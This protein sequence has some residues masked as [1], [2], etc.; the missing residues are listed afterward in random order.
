MEL[1]RK[2][3][4]L[5]PLETKNK[6]KVWI[7]FLVIIATSLDNLNVSGTLTA[8]FSIT[9]HFPNAGTTTISWVFSAYSLTLGA[10]IIIAGKL[11][12]VLGP[13]NV[14]LCGLFF[15]SIF[16]LI[17]A[18][19]V[20]EPI[21]LIVFRAIQGIFASS[22][23]PSTFAM[24]GNY[25]KGDALLK[26]LTGFIMSLTTV[27]GIGCILG[28]AFSVSSAGYKGL[29]YFTFAVGMFSFI[30]LFFLIIPIDETE[31][32]KNLKIKDL[33]FGGSFALVAGLLLIILGLTEGGH[34]WQK[35]AAYVP[36]IIG[37]LVL[38][39][40]ILFEMVYIQLFK[41]KVDSQI[42]SIESNTTHLSE[43]NKDKDELNPSNQS[44]ET[45]S[46]IPGINDWRYKIQL[47]FPREVV[48]I[49]NFYQY[50]ASTFLFYIN[51]IAVMTT[52]IQYY[53][54]VTLDSPIMT[55]VK[56]LPLALGLAVGATV[57][58]QRYAEKFGLKFVI[59]CSPIIVLTMCVWLS[60]LDFR[61]KNSYWKYE[62]FAQFFIGY[63][64]NL[65]FQVY[66]TD[67]IIGTP[68]HLQGVVS[69]ILQTA[70]QI[71]ICF[72]NA[73]IASLVGDLTLDKS[74]ES[75][76]KLHDKFKKNFYLAFA[77]SGALFL[78]LLTTKKT[79]KMDQTPKISDEE[80]GVT[81]NEVEKESESN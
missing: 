7:Y 46:E 13:H 49:R 79:P 12:D 55:A 20:K 44:V 48:S 67:I 66:W 54:Y 32:H 18:V 71:G 58:R 6:Y 76:L 73:I 29:F 25:F 16:A 3:R 14:F 1:L 78:V 43:E 36:I 50:L 52:V 27:F 4:N 69:G 28:G 19:I 26:A 35:P 62:C 63:G 65:Y 56:V 40:V 34:S 37:G 15:M 31:G 41:D 57:Y 59:C 42:K 33:D 53:Q 75:R 61:V 21:A 23:I 2:G 9:E 30:I 22:L 24:T 11:A 60:R 64:T 70:G 39:G 72:G 77:A 5:V 51:Y 68:L 81:E 8:I 45:K 38:I 47:L 10:F 80:Q 74:F 17:T